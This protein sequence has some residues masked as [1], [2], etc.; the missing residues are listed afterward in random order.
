MKFNL[1]IFCL[2]IAFSAL[3]FAHEGHDHGAST[4][5][6]PK[7]GILKTTF[8]AHFELVKLQNVINLYVY[9]KDG[10]NLPTK[11]YRLT[12]ELELP[13]KKSTP[14]ALNDKSTHWETTV[15]AKGAHRFTLKINID[16]GKEKDHV[17]FT[18]ENN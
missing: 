5:Q 4:F 16:N 9:D 1:F 15:D 12:A 6:A 11:D 2:A 8:N 13:R 17:K 14:I 10:K 3:T 18:V 7:G